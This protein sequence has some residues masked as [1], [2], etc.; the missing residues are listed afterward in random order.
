MLP[1]LYRSSNQIVA[2]DR[3]QYLGRLTKCTKCTAVE[4]LNGD[5]TLAASLAPT[6]TLLDKIQNQ[7]FIM[8]KPNPFDDPQYF[9]IY[10]MQ[11]DEV[12]RLTIS[13]R[14]IKH[15]LYNNVISPVISNGAETDT[16]SGHWNTCCLSNILSFDNFFSFS[17]NISSAAAME[18]GY[19]K[20]DT[21]GKFLEEMATAF[22]AEF[23]FNNF[24]IQ[25]MDQRGERKNYVLRWNKNIGSP[26]LSL[27]AGEVYSHVVTYAELTAKY[28]R[29]NHNY[30][31]PVQICSDPR[32]ISYDNQKLYKVYMYNAT[33]QFKEK[34]VDPTVDQ[35]YRG[36]KSALNTL[37]RQLI[38]TGEGA[39]LKTK[40]SVNLKVNYRPA[41]DEMNEVGLGDTVD[42]MLKGGRTVEAK[43]AKTE[44]DC[45]A[46]RWVSIELGEEK[47]K[48]S[49]YIA[50]R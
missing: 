48:L 34:E 6:E 5:Y 49:N 32:V 24:E 38:T 12:N 44:Y 40:E 11:F 10:D 15:C 8:A 36:I 27:A 4:K 19:T 46:E 47:M 16:P 50:R 42:V 28:T 20:A 17:S 26:N 21:I 7:R 3:M 23:H 9:E 43:I 37:S 13:A 2:P 39:K 1:L 25:L 22:G 45:L 30:E 18:R 41:L 29:D 31:Y 14:H 35:G 33:N